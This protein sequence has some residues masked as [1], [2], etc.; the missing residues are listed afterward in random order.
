MFL[1]KLAE[2][3]SCDFH[4]TNTLDFYTK[5]AELDADNKLG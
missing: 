4:C 2:K 3:R 5:I 1:L